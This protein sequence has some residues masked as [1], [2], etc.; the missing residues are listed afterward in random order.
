VY[1]C[2]QAGANVIVSGSAVVRSTDPHHA[3]S[4]MRKVVTDA[5][6]KQSH[7]ITAS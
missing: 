2:I 5:I 3:M 1:V 7:I 4:S 6:Q